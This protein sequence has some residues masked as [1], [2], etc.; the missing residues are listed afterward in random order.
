MDM[1]DTFIEQI[2]VKRKEGKEIGILV[3]TVVGGI[4]LLLGLT[5]LMMSNALLFSLIP[6][7]WIGVI[8]GAWWLILQQNI[9]FE[10]CIT[11]GDIDIDVI[12]SRR[13]RKRIVS[14][15]GAKI[16]DA[17]RYRHEQWKN[18]KVD[19]FVMTASSLGAEDLRYFT[20]HSK[21]R[22]YTLVVFEPN[23]RVSEAFR[24]GLPGPVRVVWDK[25]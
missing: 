24:K 12:I 8:A 13:K 10:Y 1:L 23:Q 3:A 2:V 6:F 4:F 14:V 22:G 11:N 9:E 15:R 21:K 25:E 18:R 7:V 5:V 16:E 17:G 19:R 20:Y